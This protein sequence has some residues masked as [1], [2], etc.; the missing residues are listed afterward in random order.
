VELVAVVGA[1]ALVEYLVFVMLCGYMRG[2]CGVPAPATSGNATFERYYRVQAN[3]LEQL[4]VFLPGL[5]LFAVYAS[6][7]GA[8]ALGALFILGRALYARGYVLDPAR[9]GPG[10]L[11]TLSANVVLVVGGL[12]GALIRSL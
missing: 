6:E 7:T 2:R 8:V 5:P 4:V 3:T 11:M 12:I 9:R 10:F 1:L